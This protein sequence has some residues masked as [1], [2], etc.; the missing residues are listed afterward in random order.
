MY[1]LYSL[2]KLT[3]VITP[4]RC[5]ARP[6]ISRRQQRRRVAPNSSVSRQLSHA[7]FFP[8]SVVLFSLRI[9]NKTLMNQCHEC[10]NTNLYILFFGRL[11][12]CSQIPKLRYVQTIGHV[13]ATAAFQNIAKV[14]HVRR[15]HRPPPRG[16]KRVE[17]ENSQCACAMYTYCY[18]VRSFSFPGSTRVSPVPFD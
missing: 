6:E 15:L 11:D 8:M 17:N 13:R 18:W 10:I 7:S 16:R 2:P 9:Y 14:L 12:F 1:S 5:P 4:R 3:F